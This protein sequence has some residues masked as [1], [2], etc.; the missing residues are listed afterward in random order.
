[1][2]TQI[3]CGLTAVVYEVAG[4]WLSTWGCA[5]FAS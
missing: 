5:V 3:L 1:M 4:E 2:R